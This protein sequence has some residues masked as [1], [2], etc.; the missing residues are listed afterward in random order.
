MATVHGAPINT[1]STQT[2][3]VQIQTSRL[4][5]FQVK[6]TRGETFRHK[7]HMFRGRD[8]SS[9]TRF[10]HQEQGKRIPDILVLSERNERKRP[11]F[12]RAGGRSRKRKVQVGQSKNAEQQPTIIATVLDLVKKAFPL[13]LLL[14]IMKSLL[15][16]VFGGGT[17]NV[18]Y[19]SS[20]VYEKTFYDENGE[21]QRLRKE[22][23]QSNVPSM[24]TNE[25]LLRRDNNG[26]RDDDA[27]DS[28]LESLDKDLRS[29]DREMDNIYRATISDDFF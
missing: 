25:N 15:G 5:A 16:F 14:T 11:S 26:R 22:N 23:V 13:L 12:S 3:I 27:V 4:L 2:K 6:G 24:I 21:V 17:S 28:Y 9:N 20:T 18:V 19:Y 10:Q 29:L 7:N 8:L 1:L